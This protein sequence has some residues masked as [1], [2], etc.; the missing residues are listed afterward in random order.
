MANHTKI[1]PQEKLYNYLAEHSTI[2][3][4]SDLNIDHIKSPKCYSKDQS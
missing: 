4:D 2:L 3:G 1:V